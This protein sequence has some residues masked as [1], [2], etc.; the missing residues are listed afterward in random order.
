M[1]NVTFDTSAALKAQVHVYDST[2][3]LI[4]TCTCGDVLQDFSLYKECE[5]GK[6][7]GFGVSQKID[8]NLIDLNKV[9]TIEPDYKIRVSLLDASNTAQFVAPTLDVVNV[10]VDRKTGDIKATAYDPIYKASEHTFSELNIT[11]TITLGGLVQAIA[12]FLGLS[13]DLVTLSSDPFTQTATSGYG[14]DESLRAIL[15]QIAEVTQTI[16]FV[17]YGS[18]ND[19]LVF[20]QLSTTSLQTYNKGAYY[21]FETEGTR[22][23]KGICNAT[24]LGENLVAES[25]IEGDIQ[26]VRDNPLWELREDLP[27]I[28]P[29]ALARVAG[30]ELAEYTLDWGG[31]PRLEIGDCITINHDTGSTKIYILSDVITYEGALNQVT[32]WEYT[33]ADAETASNPVNIGEK[34]NQTFARVNKAEKTITLYVQDMDGVKDDVSQLQLEKDRIQAS[35]S[36]IEKTTL[37]GIESVNSQ[38]STLQQQVDLAITSEDVSIQITEALE[39]GV[40]KVKTTTG[41]T[42]DEDGLHINKTGSQ[43]TSTLD[44]DGLTVSRGGTEVL[45]AVSDGVNAVNI[46]VRQYLKVGGSRFQEYGYNRTGCFWIGD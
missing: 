3:T 12:T 26:Y 7:F 41:Y 14:G 17:K 22:V 31:D 29:D 34:F 42:F 24:E 44:E 2:D 16:Y 18:D 40:T 37:D 46:T 5:M 13:Y 33:E 19:E 4:T 39:D 32:T 25:D 36:S 43:M 8:V 21:E 27:D 15:T 38:L 10:K 23:L 20:T 11:G 6:F 30:F 28:L 1:L 35:V 9:I 45:Q